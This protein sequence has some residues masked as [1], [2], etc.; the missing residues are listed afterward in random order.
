MEDGDEL[1]PNKTRVEI[2]DIIK[3]HQ[4]CFSVN[5]VYFECKL[6]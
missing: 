4:V 3:D 1:D 6:I 5:F 2:Q